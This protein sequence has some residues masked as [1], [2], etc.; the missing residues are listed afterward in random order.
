MHSSL[1]NYIVSII[2]N[3]FYFTIQPLVPAFPQFSKLPA[4]NRADIQLFT[5]LTSSFSCLL[6]L[7]LFLLSTV[8]CLSTTRF[9]LLCPCWLI[10]TI[11]FLN[12]VSTDLTKKS[13]H[14]LP[15]LLVSFNSLTIALLCIIISLFRSSECS[16]TKIL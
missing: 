12:S 9:I 3:S 2:L 4:Q 10:Q 5:R 16:K 15:R 1:W 6:T 11:N 7:T 13:F 14:F 8:W